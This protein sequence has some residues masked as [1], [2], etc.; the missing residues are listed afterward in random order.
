MADIAVHTNSTGAALIRDLEIVHT[1]ANAALFFAVMVERVEVT[2]SGATACAP[3]FTS[4]IRDSICRST[5]PLGVG[6]RFSAGGGSPVSD[7]RAVNVTAV[8]GAFGI[9]VD[10]NGGPDFAVIGSNVIAQG[11]TADVRAATDASSDADV[12]LDHS[13]YGT[14]LEEGDPDATVTDPGSGT[15]QTAEPLF[16]NP[17]AGDFHQLAASP[18]RNGG[19][20]NAELGTLDID[21]QPRVAEDIPDIGADE[22]VDVV[23]PDTRITRAPRKRSRTRRRRARATFRFVANEAGATFQ[24]KL[25]RKPWTACTSPFRRKVR[26]RRGKGARHVFRVRAIDDFGNV[27][28]TPAVY[29]WRAIRR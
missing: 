19:A 24:C 21:R 29:R 28:A 15:N 26:A 8:G 6:L 13:N 17:A 7:V 3:F 9:E 10:T 27:D 12:V 20:V 16:R 18:T 2:S 14:E 1:G 22:Y 4:T 5:A 11:G 25:D 23:R